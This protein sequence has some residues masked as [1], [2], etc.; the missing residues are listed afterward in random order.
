MNDIISEKKIDK[1]LKNHCQKRGYKYIKLNPAQYVGIPD[2]MVLTDFGTTVFFEL[3][4]Q[5]ASLRPMQE[6]W[7]DWLTEN[8][9]LHVVIDTVHLGTEGALDN[10]FNSYKNKI[11]T[12]S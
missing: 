9:H 11:L 4:S 10:L 12:G 2:R 7:K 5:G 6:K 3:K 1:W 8:K